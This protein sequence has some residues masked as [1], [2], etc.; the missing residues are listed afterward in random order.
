MDLQISPFFN[1]GK[2][3]LMDLWVFKSCQLCFWTPNG[4]LGFQKISTLLFDSQWTSRFPLFSILVKRY[5]WTIGFSKVVNSFFEIPMDLQISSFFN[6]GIG[7]T[8][9]S[10][11]FQKLSTLLLD[12]QWTPGFLKVVNSAFGLPTDSRVSK[13]CQLCFLTPNGLLVF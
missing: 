11:S 10:L 12:S 2:G 3:L 13:S 5:K 4:P 1:S 7:V 9:G 6:S 8:Y